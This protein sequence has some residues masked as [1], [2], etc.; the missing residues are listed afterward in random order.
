M[1]MMLHSFKIRLSNKSF[2]FYNKIMEIVEFIDNI[3]NTFFDT[4]GVF[5]PILGC[6]LIIIE[7]MFPILPLV[8]FITINFYYLG[9]ALGFIVSW[10]LTCIGCFLSFKLCRNVLRKHFENMLDKKESKKL[11]KLIIK[12]KDMSFSSLVILVAMP[13]TPAFMVN[14]AAG[15]AN[16]DFK[17][18][19]YAILIGKIFMVYFWGFVG[20]SLIESIKEP[21]ILLKIIILMLIAFLV[22]KLLNKKLK[23]D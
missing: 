19:I 16:M 20:T 21:T 15:L 7:S 22:S 12:I 18:Y 4:M 2:L 13:F 14:I 3:I 11:K 1:D 6:V 8:L 5:A 23:L 10:I 9:S 17:K